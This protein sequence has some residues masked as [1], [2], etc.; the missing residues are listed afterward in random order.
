[1]NWNK[2]GSV[3]TDRAPAMLGARSDFLELVKQ[4]KPNDIGMHCFI[5]RE[6]LGSRTMSQ[7]LKQTL[8]SSIKVIKYI[9]ASALNTRLF[10]KL[11]QDMELSMNLCSHYC[12]LALKREHVDVACAFTTRGH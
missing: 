10:K 3:R 2:L 6:A 9:K 11:C 4:K 12:A 1:M 7:P 5:H 8:D